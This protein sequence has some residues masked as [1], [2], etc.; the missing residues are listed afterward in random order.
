M[1][2]I[3]ST[4]APSP[5][6]SAASRDAREASVDVAILG[7]G[8]AGTAAA[9]TLRRYSELSVA[10]IEGSRYER[11]RVGETVSPGIRSMLAF[12]GVWDDFLAEGHLTAFGTSAAWGGPHL[13][14]REFLFTGRGDGW[15]LDRGRFDRMLARKV[16]ESGGLLLTG[17]RLSSCA[18]S[19]DGGFRLEVVRPGGAAAIR[20]RHLI[21]ASGRKAAL[22]RRLGA[23]QRVHDALVGVAGYYELPGDRACPQ[24]TLVEAVPDGWWYSAP[25]PGG[26]MVAVFMSDADIV[27]RRRAGEPSGFEDALAGAA[28]TRERL[29]AGRLRPTLHVRCARSQRLDPV[30]GP[31]WIA[32]GDAASAFDPLSSMGLGFALASGSNAARVA[33]DVL[34]SDGSLLP[35]YGDS[36]RRHFEQYLD[37]RRRFYALERRWPGHAFW[38]RRQQISAATRPIEPAATIA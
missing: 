13:L 31:G 26:R 24:H 19:P 15:L 32:A 33:H 3:R 23:R 38:A 14:T 22:G 5:P 30:A 21:D 2:T 1:T 28:H 9:L 6:S 36:A 4:P 18:R 8:P 11:P 29:A 35:S 16:E 25:L 27:R 34:T 10:V 12:L 17:A 37:L 7:G 20:A